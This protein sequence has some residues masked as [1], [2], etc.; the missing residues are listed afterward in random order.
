MD[1]AGLLEADLRTL[2]LGREG[3]RVSGLGSKGLKNWDEG[4]WVKGSLIHTSLYWGLFPLPTFIPR[5]EPF[6]G[7]RGLGFRI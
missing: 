4:R 6:E 7:C 5:F 1:A 3:F 2:C